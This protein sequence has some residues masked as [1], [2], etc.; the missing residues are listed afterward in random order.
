MD[1]DRIAVVARGRL[2]GM[3]EQ[4]ASLILYFRI[5]QVDGKWSATF[6]T[7]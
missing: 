4:I 2:P 7:P 3:R 6:E 1:D 5:A